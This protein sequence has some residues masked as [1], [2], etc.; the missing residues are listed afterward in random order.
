MV[1]TF[2]ATL[3]ALLGLTGFVIYYLSRR[4]ASGDQITRDIV[5][6]LRSEVANELPTGAAQLTPAQLAKAIAENGRLRAHVADQDFQLLRDTLARQFV[7]NLVV[8]GLCGVLFLA[9]IGLFVWTTVRPHPPDLSNLTIAGAGASPTPVDTQPVAVQWTKAGDDQDVS[10]TLLNAETGARTAPLSAR[11]ADG[12]LVLQPEQL[13][14][15]LAHRGVGEANS[16]R[17]V[18]QT[19]QG[20]FQSSP[21]PLAVGVTLEAVKFDETRI[22]IVPLIDNTIVPNWP[23]EARLLVYTQGPNP[24]PVSFGGKLVAGED[25]VKPDP[26]TR[27]DW[28][29]AKL[30]FIGPGDPRAVVTHLEGF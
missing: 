3:P 17:A 28:S 2:L 22:R 12:K 6:K 25:T 4:N 7:T 13:T 16:I 23:F 21:T 9:G 29:T 30:G 20:S 24:M 8:Y 1:G 14:K 18:V 5:A 10:V 11:A 15:V 19:R 26:H 27:Y